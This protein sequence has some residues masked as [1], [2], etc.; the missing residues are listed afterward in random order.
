MRINPYSPMVAGRSGGQHTNNDHRM[1][2]S[3]KRLRALAEAALMLIDNIRDQK[4]R[5]AG[6]GLGG[7]KRAR[8]RTISSDGWA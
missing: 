8:I 1:A 5:N 2:R 4:L 3:Q 6:F 7:V